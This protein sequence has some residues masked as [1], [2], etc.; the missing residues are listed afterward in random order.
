M[1]GHMV[2]MPGKL[3]ESV[4]GLTTGEASQTAQNLR[5]FNPHV[6]CESWIRKGVWPSCRRETYKFNNR[7]V[8]ADAQHLFSREQDEEYAE[9]NVRLGHTFGLDPTRPSRMKPGDRYMH[10]L[11]GVEKEEKY[12]QAH[13]L[14]P[15]GMPTHHVTLDGERW[16]LH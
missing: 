16:K 12:K 11:V 1:A 10:T 5:R 13:T 15:A 9:H 7:F 4:H 2:T 3:S 14:P 6:S 8:V